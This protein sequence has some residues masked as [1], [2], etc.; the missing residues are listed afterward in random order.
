[1]LAFPAKHEPLS[2]IKS[3]ATM[4]FV[5]QFSICL[6]LLFAGAAQGSAQNF[7]GGFNF[8]LPA[9]DGSAHT[10][11][12]EFP[13]VPI[14]AAGQVSSNAN[15][16]FYAGGQPIRFW[17]ANCAASGAFPEK[18]LAPGIAARMRRMGINL[19]RFHHMD[20]PGWGNTLFLNSATGTRTIDPVVRDRF[21]YFLAQ[22]KA[23]G[24]YS[25]INLNVSRTFRAGDGVA[26][27]DSLEDFAKG[28]T[29]F[30]PWMRFLQKEFAQ[31]ILGH[32][33]PY[34]GV[35]VG[36]DPCVAIVEMNN[37]NSLYG[38]WRA[39]ALQPF[40]RGGRLPMVYNTRLDSAW[41]A[42]L[43]TK[44]EGS[45][46]KLAEAWSAGIVPQGFGEQILNGGFE[47]GNP[48]TS[49]NLTLQNGAAATF[50]QDLTVKKVGL[51]SGKINVT[52]L[53]TGS[54]GANVRLAQA[55]FSVKKDTV[56]VLRFRAKTT[57]TAKNL[58]VSVLRD[59]APNTVYATS[60]VSVTSAW[61]LFEVIFTAPENNVGQT[62]LAFGPQASGAIWLDEA[63]VVA[64]YRCPPPHIQ[65]DL[66]TNGGF[67]TGN[68]APWLLEVYGGAAATFTV[69]N[70]APHT[71]SWNGKLNVT[72]VSGTDWHI[73]GKQIAAGNIQKDSSY[74]LEFWARAG[75][76]SATLN[77]SLLRDNA[78]YTW[79]TGRDFTVTTTWKKF[80]LA[81]IAP[82]DNVGNVRIS[83]SPKQNLGAFYFDDVKFGKMVPTGL[84]PGERLQNAS[85]ARTLY[86]QRNAF[87]W[88]RVADLAE[89]YTSLEKYHFADLRSYL[90][91]SLGVV[92]PISGSNALNGH[93]DTWRHA[94][95]DL[96]DDHAYWDHP[97][98]PGT[99]WDNWNW[100]I[101]NTSLLK[102]QY[103]ESI[104]AVTC[105]L[106]MKSKPYTISE[107]NHGFPN[108]FRTEMVPALLAYS[109]FH[110]VDGI[111]F[112]TYNGGSTSWGNDFVDGYFDLHR[113]H[114]VMGLF[115]SCAYAFRNGL[116][117]ES[118]API[119]I[120]YNPRWIYR[121]PKLDDNQYWGKFTAYDKRIGLTKSVRTSGFTN[122]SDPNF[123]VIPPIGAGPIYT[124]QTNQT[125]LNQSL[126]VLT[127]A[128]AKFCSASGFLQ[129]APN[130]TAGDLRVNSSTGFGVVTWLSLTANSLRATDK[131]LLTISSK[132]QNTGMIWDGTTT[133]H[134]NWGAAPTAIF[135]LTVM[136][137]LRSTASSICVYALD[138]TGQEGACTT[139]F[140][141][142]GYF[143]F[144]LDQ[145]ASHTIWYGISANFAAQSLADERSDAPSGRLKI[146]PNPIADMAT[147]DFS[148][149]SAGQVLVEILDEAGRVVRSEDFG[150]R[151]TGEQNL[152]LDLAG[153]P[154]GVFVCRVRAGE[155][156]WV[157]K[158]VKGDF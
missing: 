21:E 68:I 61:K 124:T 11:L 123:S 115:P 107:Y 91:N 15:G 58:L 87:T 122:A 154:V 25:D 47:T 157:E 24:I 114:S 44:Y 117:T 8:N 41:T 6:A 158:L 130:T 59:N 50:T 57:G 71:G 133:V 63:S 156:F 79:Y 149:E 31:Q 7:T 131:S 109:A 67:E 1:M 4:R 113:D 144:T 97:Q 120:N 104:C 86:S 153:L 88:Q 34:T 108:R 96:I 82:E 135:P 99:P 30:D 3:N 118:T 72:A 23:N 121:T 65:P 10:F 77:V 29:L 136:V 89:F 95:M 152:L 102:N 48:P 26:A 70:T 128:T 106:Q 13:A 76:G 27:A 62:R 54:P 2:F 55:G 111:M 116:I 98:F 17:G 83:I 140:P 90:K 139:Y 147:L 45:T 40:F 142:S 110:G 14:T 78:P 37:E 5:S 38:L 81:L 151:D 85:V 46:G 125:V 36:Q 56:Y 112:F 33:N 32:V 155:G 103:F 75:S 119:N 18:T 64:L 143:T 148:M 150:P 43:N 94:D 9:Y 20:N 84:L 105:G 129:D 28:F 137:R 39:D 16:K 35:A 126:G 93:Q 74:T 146:S 42:F 145:A 127:T 73:Q 134:S 100:L 141:T 19:I 101:N 22:L 51:A 60:T 138:A 49:W 69:S 92:A 52:N 66:M 12:P 80:T 132:I 53:G